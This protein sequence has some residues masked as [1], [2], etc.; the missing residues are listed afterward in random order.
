MK[1]GDR[2]FQISMDDTIFAP[3]DILII[4]EVHYDRYIIVTCNGG[5]EHWCRM[6]A[7]RVGNE[8]NRMMLEK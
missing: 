1:P 5:S 2:V 4:K 3:N 8:K 6:Y 7:F